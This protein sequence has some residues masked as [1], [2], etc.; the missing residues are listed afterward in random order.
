MLK[1]ALARMMSVSVPRIH[2]GLYL[3]YETGKFFLFR[4]YRARLRFARTRGRRIILECIEQFPDAEIV[5]AGA[6]EYR[7]QITTV[8]SF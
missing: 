7:C 1:L 3:E 6:K 5:D 4:R 8:I 2:V